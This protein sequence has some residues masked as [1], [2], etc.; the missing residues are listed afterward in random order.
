MTDS[1][2]PVHVHPAAPP[3]TPDPAPISRT[4]SRLSSDDLL[5]VPAAK[6]TW[7]AWNFTA[8]WLG[9]V[10]NI[11][12]F[13]VIGSM[14]G[15]G[16]SAFQ[17]L[18]AVFI[19]CLIQL[20]FL[21][22]TGRV[23]SRFGIPFPVWARA[24]FGTYGSNIP[25]VL[26]GITAIFWFGI[27]N[28]LGASVLNALFGE[29][30]PFWASLTEHDVFGL[31]LN[32]WICLLVFWSVNF[33]VIRHGIETIRKFESW[34][35]PLVLV[36]MVG[37]VVWALKVGNG[38]GPV[39]DSPS[40]YPTVSNFVAFGLIPAVA[41]FMNAGF[42]TMILNY[43]DISRFARSNR[44]Q[45]IGTF[46]GLPVGT[47]VYY[48]MAA[49]IVSGTQA[50]YGTAIWDPG[51]VLTAIGNPFVTIVGAIL[52]TVATISVNIPANLISPAYDLVN[53]FPRRFTFKSGAVVAILLAFAYCPW[54]WMRDADSLYSLLDNLG[55]FLGPATGILIADFLLLRRGRLDVDALYDPNGRYRYFKGFNPVA[56]GTLV[57]G[58]V[59]LILLKF[60]E[61]TSSLYT[62]SWF[63]G[64]AFGFVVYSAVSFA[65]RG[66]SATLD[67]GLEPA[68]TLGTEA[69]P[70]KPE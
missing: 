47:F 44:A 55:T 26:R 8:L 67:A 3:S 46:V 15:T 50:A 41:V 42:I 40:D 21:T 65:V 69:A 48:G 2:T 1:L 64:L 53:L 17:A 28:Y 4:D 68:G 19:A 60:V 31:S 70:A 13:T 58:T 54:V 12:G 27:Q 32:L 23:G 52:L 43:P 30:F 16:L 51:E 49:I 57:A 63:L 18:T 20:V 5:P 24:A 56:I 37:L 36:V 29:V 14:M 22:L 39:F 33:I 34:A 10:H 25:A 7:G 38:L 59:C 6:R 45:A 11:F 62:Y 35:G 61:A 9:M 66:R